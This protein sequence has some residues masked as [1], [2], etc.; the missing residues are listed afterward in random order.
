MSDASFNPSIE[1]PMD[2]TTT[3]DTTDTLPVPP[4]LSNMAFRAVALA[5]VVS[6]RLALTILDGNDD[7]DP[8]ALRAIAQ[9]LTV[10]LQQRDTYYAQQRRR[11]KQR[12]K[13]LEKRIGG[14]E[15]IF[16]SVPEGYEENNGRLPH[17]AIPIG[18]GRYKSAKY[19]KQLEG[20]WVAGFTDED[21]PH[22]MPHIAEL[23]AS[24]AY[25]IDDTTDDPTEPM[26]PWFRRI[27]FGHA[28]LFSTMQKA[29]LELDDWG[30]YAEV[31]QHRAYDVE[32][33]TTVLDS[34]TQLIFIK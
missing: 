28:A 24:P 23:F 5:P 19:I 32:L 27:L 34:Q 18:D 11:N 21:G 16:D 25:N 10:T 30:L 2:D 33:G 12:I 31:S 3:W 4:P 14:Y 29:I 13:E 1:S 9:G 7:I 8:D 20:G 15:E 26:P 6:P 22:S 17:L